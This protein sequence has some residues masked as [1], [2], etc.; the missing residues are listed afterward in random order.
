[1]RSSTI[2][3]S[4]WVRCTI[5]RDIASA[6]RTAEI[7]SSKDSSC[8][9]TDSACAWMRDK[10]DRA[11]S[12]LSWRS[13]KDDRIVSCAWVPPNDRKLGINTAMPITTVVVH[14]RMRNR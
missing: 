4:I 10:S 7:C 1:M 3:M 5:F 12:S 14:L 9:S 13:S 2:P 8:S 6:L 11:L